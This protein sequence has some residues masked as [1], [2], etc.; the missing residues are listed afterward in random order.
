MSRAV[1]GIVVHPPKRHGRSEEGHA[2]R[3]NAA[4]LPAAHPGSHIAERAEGRL[5][6]V[7]NKNGGKWE[8]FDATEPK[9]SPEE[10]AAKQA[11]H[12]AEFD[13][14]LKE[15][16]FQHWDARRQDHEQERRMLLPKI[17][18]EVDAEDQQVP[19]EKSWGIPGVRQDSVR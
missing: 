5:Q 6:Y 9:E 10:K 14:R 16:E 18:A 15:T 7:E 12:N 1:A 19:N 3:T 8:L 11:E 17:I 2:A 4:A 13:A